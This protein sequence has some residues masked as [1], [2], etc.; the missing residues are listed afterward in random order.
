M[1]NHDQAVFI[2]RGRVLRDGVMS[3]DGRLT[4]ARLKD[5]AWHVQFPLADENMR[6]GEPHVIIDANDGSVKEVFYTQ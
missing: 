6:G 3:L 4:E 5:G 1:I 2:A